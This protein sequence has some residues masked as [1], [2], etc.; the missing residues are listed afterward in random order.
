MRNVRQRPGDMFF[1][2]WQSLLRVLVVGTLAYAGLVLILRVSGK[3]MLSKMNAFDLVVTIALGS[4][5]AT[6]FLSRE[7]TVA[8]VILATALL[9]GL[10]SL[11]V[12]LSFRFD[13]FRTIVTAEPRL[14]VFDGRVLEEAIQTERLPRREL[15]AAVRRAGLT[16]V[17]AAFAV[18][19]ETNGAL[20]VIPRDP[21][22][23]DYPALRS[24][25]GVPPHGRQR[26]E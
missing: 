20:T 23:H 2:D 21:D 3:R 8:T 11:L 4:I 19:L 13:R 25:R 17:Q 1:N 14:L 16:G 26:E 15:D 12:F 7:V 22:A 5:L 24:V 10:Q 9:M 18:V 6:A